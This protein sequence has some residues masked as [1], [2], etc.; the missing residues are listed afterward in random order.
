MVRACVL[1]WGSDLGGE[2]GGLPERVRS[3][4]CFQPGEWREERRGRLWLNEEA[5]EMLAKEF[6]LC[7]KSN[8][9]SSEV[10]KQGSDLLRSG[11][12]G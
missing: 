1:L 3:Q 2:R 11:L 12:S 8:G 10:S 6:G 4:L 7:Q 9:D 5:F